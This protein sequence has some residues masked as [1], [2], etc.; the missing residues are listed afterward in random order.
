MDQYSIEEIIAIEETKGFSLS[1]HK[2]FLSSKRTAAHTLTCM[3]EN[4]RNNTHI[5]W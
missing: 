4:Q 2:M 1:S 5:H 3:D